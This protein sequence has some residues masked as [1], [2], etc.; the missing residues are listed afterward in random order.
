M[1]H[2]CQNFQKGLGVVVSLWLHSGGNEYPLSIITAYGIAEQCVFN[3]LQFFHLNENVAFDVMH[4]LFEGVCR[5]EMGQ[6]VYELIFIQKLFSLEVLNNRIQYFDFGN[7][8]SVNKPVSIS[9]AAIKKKL[10]ILSASEMACF[11][12]FFGLFIGDLVPHDNKVWRIWVLLTELICTV[13]SS[14][15]SIESLSYLKNV[16]FEHHSLYLETFND[17]IL[18]PK[19]HFLLHYP[20]PQLQ[21]NLLS[22]ICLEVLQEKLALNTIN[23][24]NSV[25]WVNCYGTMYKPKMLVIV[26]NND[27]FP[28]FGDIRNIIVNG[29]NILF[30]V[31]ILQTLSFVEHYHAYEVKTTKSCKLVSRNDLEYYSTFNIHIL[32]NGLR[33]EIEET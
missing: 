17:S 22:S 28:T 15:F 6:I 30:I 24:Y 31:T 25:E 7:K 33:H 19:H 2:A 21:E 20:R 12:Q 5:H 10:I 26:E 27:I 32:S 1:S 29:N 14:S 23:N 9:D 16:I 13:M 18:K 8:Y 3:Q 11:V 4:D